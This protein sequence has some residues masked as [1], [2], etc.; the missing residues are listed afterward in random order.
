M[1]N[2][3]SREAFS[4]TRAFEDK[5]SGCVFCIKKSGSLPFVLIR[6]VK[7]FSIFSLK[8]VPIRNRSFR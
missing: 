5:A 3:V 2:K 1:S 7:A 4:C 8:L 6:E